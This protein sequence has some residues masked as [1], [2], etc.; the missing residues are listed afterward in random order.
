MSKSGENE[1]PAGRGGVVRGFLRGNKYFGG[2]LP[3]DQI[4]KPA[5]NSTTGPLPVCR[6]F[7][8]YMY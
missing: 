3:M 4:N 5:V 1:I 7:T 8:V 2:I 6:L